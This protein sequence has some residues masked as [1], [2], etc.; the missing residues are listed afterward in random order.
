MI[1]LERDDDAQVFPLEKKLNTY[2][3]SLPR[4]LK[5]MKNAIIGGDF[6]KRFNQLR[7]ERD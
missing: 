3:H 6:I 5:N 2:H 1:M 4:Q 7:K